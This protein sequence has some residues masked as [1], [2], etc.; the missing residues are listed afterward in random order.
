MGSSCC[1]SDHL[2]TG[3][4][5]ARACPETPYSAAIPEFRL[6]TIHGSSGYL[7]VALLVLH[8]FRSKFWNL[9]T[10]EG[11]WTCSRRYALGKKSVIGQDK[12]MALFF[13]QKKYAFLAFFS[14]FVVMATELIATRVIAPYIGVSIFTWTT[15][16]S[17]ILLGISVGN[18]AGGRLADRGAP[19]AKF[20]I[21]GSL[22]IAA[23]PL[24]ARLIP[25]IATLNLGLVSISLLA[26]SLLFLGPAILLGT[27]Y[28][29]ILRHSLVSRGLEHAGEHT[30]L[31]SGLAA[32]GSIVGTLMTGFFFIGFLGTSLS[33]HILA[34]LLFLSSLWFGKIVS[35][36]TILGI[37][38]LGM[39]ILAYYIFPFSRGSATLS[40]T[41]ST[42]YKIT[43][44]ER[45]YGSHPSRML[46]LDFDSHSIE[47][48]D[49]ARMGTYQ[50][51]SPVFKVFR[52]DL[53][54]ILTI[55]SGSYNIAKD[56]F[57][58]YHADITAVEID[59][60]VTETARRFFDLDSYP[61]RTV[62][63]DGRFYLETNKDTYDLIFGD[64]FNSFI[65]M[66]WYLATKEAIYAAKTRLNPGGIY[67]LDIISALTGPQAQLFESV[68]K[69]FSLVFP[70]YYMIALGGDQN[71]QQS[72]ILVGINSDT[73][74]DEKKLAYELAH[75]MKE[76][77]SHIQARYQYQPPL[78]NDAIILTDDYA[79]VERLNA[80]LI[81]AYLPL[82]TRWFYSIL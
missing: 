41:E 69:T 45:M 1:H 81:Q 74:I 21:I 50:D 13:D 58:L 61:F 24:L 75:L 22:F 11:F 63:T 66:P 34:L 59:P 42:Y 44:L 49:G 37:A 7:S 5:I 57:R 31:L 14:G 76:S 62:N 23:I 80:S 26:A 33:L 48:M 64:A 2:F 53:R 18:Y 16:I 12:K 3:R 47:S 73:R 39:L 79:P 82:Y 51:I 65:S 54:R 9:A 32:L 55:G 36:Q 60:Q 46:F 40:E 30:G 70:N 67:A 71:F 68:A 10:K 8:S 35:K 72:I 52:K 4:I 78:P 28:P 43:V 38:I 56:L 77:D 29:F 6:Q 19:F 27:M 20:L 17:T 25:F 15:I